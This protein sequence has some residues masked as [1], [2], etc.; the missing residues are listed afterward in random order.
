MASFNELLKMKQQQNKKTSASREKAREA[1]LN[2]FKKR[3]EYK[4]KLAQDK[5]EMNQRVSDFGQGMSNYIDNLRGI[6]PEKKTIFDYKPI[7]NQQIKNNTKKSK[8]SLNPISTT[9][10]TKNTVKKSSKTVDK[11]DSRPY[12][13]QDID[14]MTREEYTGEKLTPVKKFLRYGFGKVP[15]IGENKKI[16]EQYRN[17]EKLDTN[18]MSATKKALYDSLNP[19]ISTSKRVFQG[20]EAERFSQTAVAAMMGENAFE[21]AKPTTGNKGIDTAIDIIGTIAGYTNASSGLSLGGGSNQ[22]YKSVEGGAKKLLTSRFPALA[23]RGAEKLD[24]V[25]GIVK[26]VAGALIEG[27]GSGVP[28]AL[29]EST[30]QNKNL[31]D[32]MKYV[33]RDMAFGG[34]FNLGLYGLG[35]AGGSIGN[36]LFKGAKNVDVDGKNV[37]VDN[38]TKPKKKLKLSDKNLTAKQ[39]EARKTQAV[40]YGTEK[41]NTRNSKVKDVENAKVLYNDEISRRGSD[42]VDYSKENLDTV[43]K[44]TNI[45]P[46]ITGYKNLKRNKQLLK[47]KKNFKK[48][49]DFIPDSMDEKSAKAIYNDF[50]KSKEEIIKNHIDNYMKKT[51][52]QGVEQGNIIRDDY[53]DV[54]GRFG[55]VSKNDKWYS[56]FYRENNKYPNKKEF[57]Q[58]AEK[59]LKEGFE[60]NGGKIEPNKGYLEIEK[61]Q[62][63]IK[64]KFNIDKD[65]NFTKKKTLTNKID[66]IKNNE[67]NINRLETTE[68]IK[69]PSIQQGKIKSTMKPENKI[70]KNTEGVSNKKTSIPE[71]QNKKIPEGDIKKF[72]PYETPKIKKEVLQDKKSFDSFYNLDKDL[73]T[74]NQK[75]VKDRIV[76]D[77]GKRILNKVKSNSLDDIVGYYK[78]K[79]QFSHDIKIKPSLRS[80]NAYARISIPKTGL[81]A[82][83]VIEIKV[84][85]NKPIDIQV[86]SIRHELEHYMDIANNNFVGKNPKKIMANMRETYGIGGHHKNYDYFEPDYLR[87]SMLKEVSESV[88]GVKIKPDNNINTQSIKQ[89]D[90]AK[91]KSVDTAYAEPT[92]SV[93]SIN[94]EAKTKLSRFKEVTV[95]DSPN[96]TPEMKEYL[97]RQMPKEYETVTNKKDWKNA[98][99]TVVSEGNEKVWNRLKN[100]KSLGSKDS[101]ELMALHDYYEAAGDYAKANE[102]INKL[103]GEASTGG[104]FIQALSIWN[105]KTTNGMLMTAAQNV[106]KS[107]DSNKLVIKKKNLTSQMDELKNTIKSL[108][109]KKASKS[110]IDL[111][112]KLLSGKE[113]KLDDIFAKLDKAYGKKDVIKLQKKV[114]DIQYS[115]DNLNDKIPKSKNKSFWQS[116]LDE[117]IKLLGDT[118][119]KLDKAKNDMLNDMNDLKT[120]DYTFIKTKL[121]NYKSKK[122][123]DNAYKTELQKITKGSQATP[124]QIQKATERATR[125]QLIE[126]VLAMQR[127]ADLEGSTFRDKF[128]GIQRIMMLQGIGTLMRNNVANTV[129]GI[130]EVGVKDNTIAPV[131]DYIASA[132]RTKSLINPITEPAASGRTTLFMP[133]AKGKYYAKGLVKGAVDTG[134]DLR[135]SIKYKTWIDTNPARLDIEHAGKR[136]FKWKIGNTADQ[137]VR[138]MVSDR[139]FYQAAF[140]ARITE[141]KKINKTSTTTSAMED[142]AKVYALDKTFQNNSYLAQ[143]MSTIKRKIPPMDLVIPFSQTPANLADKLGDYALVGSLPKLIKQIG[144]AKSGNFDQKLFVDTVGR[145][146][147]G[148]GI[149]VLGYKLAENGII[150]GGLSKSKKIRENELAQ[151]KKAYSI[152]LGDT[153]YSYDWL[154]PT[155]SILS[156]AADVYSTAKGKAGWQQILESGAVAAGDSIVNQTMLSGLL[157]MFSGYSPTS[158]ILQSLL[159]SSQQVQPSLIKSLARTIDGTERETKDSNVFYT[160]ANR[161]KS[162]IPV[163]RETLPEKVNVYGETVKANQYDNTFKNALNNFVNPTRI[164]KENKSKVSQE[165]QR[166]YEKTGASD[167]LIPVAPD[168]ASS[169]NKYIK[170]FDPETLKLKGKKESIEFKTA[171]E[172]VDWKKFFGTKQVEEVSSLIDSGAYKNRSDDEKVKMIKSL[173]R[174]NSN[175]IKREYINSKK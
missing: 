81:K 113:K 119:K 131:L 153:Y 94:A 66:E 50:N 11:K 36:K 150:T 16:D 47:L 101:T 34:G 99:D 90:N 75:S 118:T 114:K 52:K 1:W 7:E 164:T 144:Q 68:K 73:K 9:K 110:E 134:R 130:I 82:D 87:R 125:T 31:N 143:T 54:V 126:N 86:G 42:I 115:I 40:D 108:E 51:S 123:F 117:K 23:I 166:L 18:E 63:E 2:A 35:K 45:E 91:I 139:P 157:D 46:E 84:N 33:A 38:V 8:L 169:T 30:V 27:A 92:K 74:V 17:P 151:G 72:T 48:G 145:M 173:F 102:V 37:D 76:G 79:Y 172:K 29:I 21:V 111:N 158:G 89:I 137:I 61:Y 13:K 168:K 140:D 104:Q 28:A 24:K 15:T 3:D 14:T 78:N 103:S 58:I 167:M 55:R 105:K 67:N 133:L 165:L 93:D 85:P 122:F 41:I 106:K 39:I 10:P 171:K 59:H 22:A 69:Q 32:T 19:I 146:F 120:K 148:G 62:N 100:V 170:E 162:G 97:K 155:G 138:K 5:K 98:V 26:G 80:D 152:K 128:R 161:F 70:I 65:G 160:T 154:S 159:G 142:S 124:K 20:A 44:K 136:V 174:K 121:D 135:D 156:A 56:D 88:D 175:E 53:G 49:E 71:V 4:A 116:K 83:S 129:N 147:T 95:K 6:E 64:K 132:A 57:R 163:L 25:P 112:L 109:A 149:A 43:A 141:L 77:I 12:F 107:F 96:T 60:S 127:I